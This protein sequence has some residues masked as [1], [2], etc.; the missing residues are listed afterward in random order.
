MKE[1]GRVWTPGYFMRKPTIIVNSCSHT[2]MKTTLSLTYTLKTLAQCTSKELQ[3]FTRL[4]QEGDE[5]NT[6]L[7]DEGIHRAYLLGFCYSNA[8]LVGVAALKHSDIGHQ[9]DVF[10]RARIPH[11]AA[12]YHTEIGY[13]STKPNHRGHGICP[14]LVRRLLEQIDDPVFASARLQN[15]TATK[16]L[17]SLGFQPIGHRF[18][19][20]HHLPEVY[21]VQLFV[22][23]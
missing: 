9:N 21:Y 6:N 13:V 16:I 17:Q 14:S 15:K 12:K 2:T 1:K 4:V 7:L 18:R 20:R 23:P 22:R 3:S 10:Q 11:L 8:E 19:G 5:A